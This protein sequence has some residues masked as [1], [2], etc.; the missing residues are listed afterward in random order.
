MIAEKR[1]LFF[2]LFFDNQLS[3]LRSVLYIATSSLLYQSTQSVI[4]WARM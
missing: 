1:K 3:L 4:T 2:F